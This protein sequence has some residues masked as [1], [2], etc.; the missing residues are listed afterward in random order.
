MKRL[1]ALALICAL[2]M[3]WALAEA[4]DCP[5]GLPEGVEWGDSPQ[6]L[7]DWEFVSMEDIAGLTMLTTDSATMEGVKATLSYCFYNDRLIGWDVIY[8]AAD[9]PEAA[10]NELLEERF[11][12][13]MPVDAERFVRMATAIQPDAFLHED[14]ALVTKGRA[15]E[16]APG[17]L[18]A[19]VADNGQIEMAVFAEALIYELAAQAPAVTQAPGLRHYDDY[20]ARRV[21]IDAEDSFLEAVLQCGDM[22]ALRDCARTQPDRFGEALRDFLDNSTTIFRLPDSRLMDDVERMLQSGDV[23]PWS[24]LPMDWERLEEL[25]GL[26]EGREAEYFA[27][28]ETLGHIAADESLRAD[29]YEEYDAAL[30]RLLDVD[31]DIAAVLRAMVYLPHFTGEYAEEFRASVLYDTSQ[32]MIAALRGNHADRITETD[33]AGLAARLDELYAARAECVAALEDIEKRIGRP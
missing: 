15:Y 17:I 7:P 5:L 12:P 20:S 19:M 4:R 26:R 30:G 9:M 10:L 29:C 3:G 13:S 31:E 23:M 8:D 28:A 6:A 14:D 32:E 24:E 22:E 18:A 11:G 2:A 1:M 16:P 21:M 27:Y 33:P 25:I